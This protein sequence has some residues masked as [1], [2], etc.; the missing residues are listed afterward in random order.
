MMKLSE[1]GNTERNNKMKKKMKMRMPATPL[2]TID[3][4]FSV[5]SHDDITKKFPVHWTGSQNA[6]RGIVTIDGEP[7][8]F[9]GMGS[10]N[11]LQQV[12]VNADALTSEY[13]FEGAGIRLTA[14]FTSPLLVEELYYASRPVSYL[15]LSVESIDGREHSVCAKVSC[16]EEFVLN[17]AGEGRALSEPVSVDGVT[18]I[19]MGNGE[20]KVLWRSGDDLRIDWG[21]LY[22]GV[23][24]NGK[25]GA[26]VFDGL[27]AVY[28]ETEVE[29]ETLFLLGYDDISSIV[30]F[31]EQLSA[32]WKKDGKTIEQAMSEAAAEYE[33]LKK[34][35][36]GFAVRLT[37][38]A[39][40]KGGEEY[41]ELLSLA[42]RQV[43]AAHK[44]VVDKDGNYLYISKECF[45]NGCAATV[46]VTYPSAPMYLRYNTE[47]LKG[48][49][50]PVLRYARTGEWRW[51]FAPHD[52]GTYPLLNGQ[53]YFP[54]KLEGQMPVEECGNMLILIDAICRREEDYTL[55]EENLDLMETWSKYL[56]QYGEDPENQLCTDDFAGHMP[57]NVNL[58]IKAVM[59]LSGYAD[60]LHALEQETRSKEVS[61]IAERFAKSIFERAKNTDGSCR[62]AFDRPDTFSLKYNAV[63]DKLWGTNL[64]DD[65][66]YRGEMARYKKEAFPYGVPLDSRAGYTKSDWE[67]WIACLAETD[68]DFRYFVHLI[69]QAFHTMHTRVPMTDWYHA[70]TSEMRG[71]LHRSVQGGLFMK[72]LLD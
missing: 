62:L 15:Y 51:D 4:Y 23:K 39:T 28:A 52:V 40:E 63:W 41:A 7:H 35:C 72:L 21:Y 2:V 24:G 69:Y 60:V 61:S 29:K 9:I 3:P 8:R 17:R 36:D 59:G 54:D 45:S 68:E 70:D 10:E 25:C 1:D 6:M 43:M 5:W 32:Y 34:N 19:R 13:V 46:D 44:L 48:M 27:Y 14:R 56:E 71:F 64:F 37:E 26:E 22:L 67:L 47:L 20:Q 30:Y 11:T 31:G 16:S 33:S 18:A 42:Y 65:E 57:H 12:A 50:R 53:T 38:E 49:L 55:A 58:A 66:F